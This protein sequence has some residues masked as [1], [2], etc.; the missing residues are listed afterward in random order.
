MTVYDYI[1]AYR[2]NQENLQD[3]LRQLFPQAEDPITVQVRPRKTPAGGKRALCW[4]FL[5]PMTDRIAAG[6]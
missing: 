3:Y 5:V 1:G 2:L 4:A 6:S